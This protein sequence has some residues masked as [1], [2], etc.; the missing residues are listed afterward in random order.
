MG[1]KIITVIFS[2]LTQM[3]EFGKP[4]FP[5]K[6]NVYQLYRIM[7]AEVLLFSPLTTLTH[8]AVLSILSLKCTDVQSIYYKY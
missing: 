6:F 3:I 4:L 2:F 1:I 5:F 8:E 7:T